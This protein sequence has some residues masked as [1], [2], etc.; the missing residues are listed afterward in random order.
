MKRF[1]FVSVT[2]YCLIALSCP[3]VPGAQA[4]GVGGDTA[5]ETNWLYSFPVDGQG[6]Q[7]VA[8]IPL[9]PALWLFGSGLMGIAVV[10]RRRKETRDGN[11]SRSRNKRWRF[12]LLHRHD[13]SP[14]DTDRQ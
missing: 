14:Q 3:I 4:T 12:H 9:P 11:T 7:A 2:C 13:G 1:R 8:S 6:S 5:F 10:A